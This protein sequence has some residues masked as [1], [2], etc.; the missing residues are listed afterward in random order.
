M[1][2][3][4]NGLSSATLIPF[5]E[6][7]LSES[8]R[9]K[10]AEE[11]NAELDAARK[12]ADEA[13]AQLA[14]LKADKAASDAELQTAKKAAEDA[15]KAVK[16]A[17]DQIDKITFREKKIKIKSVKSTSKRSAKVSWKK[18][19]GANGYQIQ[20]AAKSNFKSRKAITLKSGKTVVKTIRKLKSKK[21]YY[22][23]MRAYKTI[24]G[25]TVY[26]NYSPV[27]KVTVK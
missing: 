12:A 24:A 17:Q 26:T 15:L 6:A 27:K 16:A 14:A 8:N 20:Y 13:K 19:S 7:K 4:A 18:V 22:L 11:L 25:K 23:R 10:R 9:I 2:Y 21:T 1:K 5:A 3:Y